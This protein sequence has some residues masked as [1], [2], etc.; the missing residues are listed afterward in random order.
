MILTMNNNIALLMYLSLYLSLTC[1][2]TPAESVFRVR[3]SADE[4]KLPTI[5]VTTE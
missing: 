2:A 1:F 3:A 5:T 4:T